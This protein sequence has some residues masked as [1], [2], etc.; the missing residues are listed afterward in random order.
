MRAAHSIK[1][2]AR[3]VGV[4]PAVSVAH[5][6]ED[7]F[8]AARRDPRLVAGGR[9][10]LAAGGGPPGQD[11]GSD[12]GPERGPGASVRRPGEVARRRARGDAR[13]GTGRPAASSPEVAA[14]ARPP[15][16][17]RPRA[18]IGTGR[19]SRSPSPRATAASAVDDRLPGI[20]DSAAAE[21]I[22]RQF[23]S[24][25]EPG[26]RPVRF[27]MRATKD[28]DVQGLAFLAAV[29]RHAADAAVRLWSW[30]GCPTEMATVLG[31][32]GLGEP[33][34]RSPRR[35]ARGRMSDGIHA[36][37][38]VTQAREHLTVLEQV[39]LSLEKPGSRTDVRER[40]DRCFRIVHSIKGDAGF[41]GLHGHSHAGQRDRDRPGNLRD[42]GFAGFDPGRRA[43][44]R[45][46]RPPRD[47]R[48]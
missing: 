14:V 41:L 9:R 18:R 7:C 38:F 19:A 40:I 47:A 46:P 12:Q 10:R 30:R 11:L 33:L 24:A 20:L 5:V 36:D 27:D 22:R 45:G 17:A 26:V 23:L 39:L 8:V 15:S 34:R 13:S 31:V 28:L 32:T 1:G 16:T 25:I 44:P 2:A 37:E 29:P 6:M 48:G 43:A 42:R 21:E 35:G 4:D 3:V